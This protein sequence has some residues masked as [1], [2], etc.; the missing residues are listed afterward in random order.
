MVRPNSTLHVPVLAEPHMPS[1]CAADVRCK[2][3]KIVVLPIL[4]QSDYSDDDTRRI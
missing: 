2:D 4:C 3:V 1:F